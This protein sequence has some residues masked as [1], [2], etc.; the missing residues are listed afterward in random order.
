LILA[1]SPYLKIPHVNPLPADS[2]ADWRK[3]I[4]TIRAAFNTACAKANIVDFRL[5]DLRH[6][7]VSNMYRAGVPIPTIQ[8]ITG[9]KSLIMFMRYNKVQLQDL[10]AAIVTMVTF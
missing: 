4:R 2:T 10:K 1:S 5:H 8:A 6:C 3:P 7:F 9:H